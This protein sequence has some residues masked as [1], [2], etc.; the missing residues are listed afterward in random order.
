MLCAVCCVHAVFAASMVHPR[1]VDMLHATYTMCKDLLQHDYHTRSWPLLALHPD[2]SACWG[3]LVKSYYLQAQWKQ[4]V[5]GF[6]L[7]AEEPPRNAT[8]WDY[9]LREAE[10]LSHDVMQVRAPQ[11]VPAMGW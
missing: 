11:P 3:V 7:P 8:H 10:W 9:L 2:R 1:F 6:H 4:L 5:L